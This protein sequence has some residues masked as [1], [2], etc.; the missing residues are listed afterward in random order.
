MGLSW[1]FKS[2]R[3]YMKIK[4]VILEEL[5]ISIDHINNVQKLLIMV[6]TKLLDRA[7]KHDRSKTEHPELDIFNE[8]TPKLKGTT[9][10]SNEYNE[11]LAEMKVA[12][13]HH[14]AKNRHHPEHFKNGVNDMTLIDL[15]EMLCD[16]KAATLR[17][18]DGNIRKSL[19]IN[20]A[21]F[22]IDTQLKQVL[23]NTI[24]LF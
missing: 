10:G 16:W 14:Y 22:N 5:D 13:D 19:D 6:V 1:R 2:A 20:A 12:L 3:S 21:R 24:E 17:H 9:Y 8:Y 7:L 15:V 23:L 18:D 11:F 4:K